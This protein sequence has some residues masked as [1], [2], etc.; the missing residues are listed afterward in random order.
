MASLLY[1][2]QSLGLLVTK[3]P[4]RFQKIFVFWDSTAFLLFGICFSG[5][6][7]HFC[8][9]TSK[10]AVL[11]QSFWSRTTKRVRQY[12]IFATK[13][14]N[15]LYCPNL[16]SQIE[17]KRCTIPIFEAF[18]HQETSQAP[19]D[20]LFLW[21]S[22]AF[23]LFGICFSGTVQHFCKIT[24]KSAVLSQSFCGSGPKCA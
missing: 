6:V 14:A 5:T 4:H 1:S 12:S 11:S 22:T 3:K 15:V 23:L 21:D 8:K 17:Q 18:G 20:L 19:K 24:S 9:K 16:V 2:S 10:S 13:P 7:Q